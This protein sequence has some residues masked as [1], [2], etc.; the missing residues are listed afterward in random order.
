[1]PEGFLIDSSAGNHKQQSRVSIVATL[2]RTMN[3]LL[4]LI[5]GQRLTESLP[6]RFAAAS[7]CG[8]H[9]Q[10][11]STQS[12]RKSESRAMTRLSY[13]CLPTC[14]GASGRW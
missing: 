11:P 6:N 1:M 5:I 3:S 9:S 4:R 13:H 8:W 12:C 2:S 14:R 10:G 7:L